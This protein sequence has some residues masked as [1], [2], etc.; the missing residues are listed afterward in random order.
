MMVT[1]QHPAGV[2]A[3]WQPTHL[4]PFQ[5]ASCAPIVPCQWHHH[6]HAPVRATATPAF[7]QALP[8]PVPPTPTPACAATVEPEQPI[9]YGSFGVVWSVV[10][11]RTGSRA[12]LKKIPSISQSLLATIR[13]FREVKILCEMN[14]RNL[15][16]ATDLIHPPPSLEQFNDVY[17]VS[18]LMES[19]LHQ[20]IV[21]P[22]HLTED[23][24]KVFIYQILRGLKYLHSAGII[25][26]DLK[27]G[28]L[29]V[30][31]NCLLKICDFGF[32]RAVEPDPNT[33]MTLEV[34]TQYYRAP[35]LL[36]GC[37]HYD[38][39]IDMW[40]VGCIFA[41]L[42]GRRILFEASSP[43]AQLE[44]ITDLLGTPSLEDLG[45]VTSPTAVRNLLSKPKPPA[46]HK[47]YALSHNITHEAAHMLSQM[48][49][50]N[51]S[52]RLSC[53]DALYH[54]FLEE[55]R[56]RYHTFLCSCCHTPSAG[57]GREF[58]RD[59]EPGSPKKFDPGYERELSTIA[60]A[61]ARLYHYIRSTN[62]HLPPLYI[63]ACSKQY[64]QFQSCT[65]GVPLSSPARA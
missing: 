46:L 47:F 28:N 55:G 41:E 32:A 26:R 50:F 7:V 29:L 31:S 43:T 49:V 57:G 20:I 65:P 19:D 64:K 21:S 53:M 2:A 13:T 9:G 51:P 52:K 6:H 1:V 44:M 39:A 37:K 56:I 18:D 35:E 24:V 11:P 54:P 17:V 42:L 8:Q 22:Q 14:H 34:V 4:L 12:A 59:L 23:H 16:S 60:K 63:N 27:P 36:A 5:A 45:H 30:N 3:Y 15:L 10:N 62:P 25:H 38:T 40:S 58:C 48:L 33:P 61:K